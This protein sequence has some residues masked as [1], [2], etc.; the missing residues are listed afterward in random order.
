M[1]IKKAPLKTKEARKDI[2]V[3]A[4]RAS[5]TYTRSARNTPEVK[6]RRKIAFTGNKTSGK[7]NLY[8]EILLSDL[9]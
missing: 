6:I 1:S 8:L 9:S 5:V 4:A 3:L 7:N 2:F